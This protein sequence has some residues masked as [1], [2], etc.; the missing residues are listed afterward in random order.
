MPFPPGFLEEL[1]ARNPIEQVISRY[2]D[3]KR[4][5]SNLVGLCPFHSERSPSFTVFKDHFHCF[6]CSAG[7]DVI[8]FVMRMENLE[9]PDAIRFLADRCGM[10]VPENDAGVFRKKSALTRERSFAM[11]KLAARHFYEN[12]NT[13]E[14]AAAREYLMQKR[15]LT[16]ATCIRFGLGYAK[17]SFNDLTDML[18]SQG[19]TPEEIQENFLCGFSKKNGRPFDMFR[20]RVMFPIIDTTGNIIA[21]G[22]R[23]MDDSKPKYLNSSDT[24][25]FKKS[26]NLFALN[27]AKNV[28]LGDKT[29][30]DS[31][32]M[33]EQ[34]SYARPGELII[35]EGYMDVIA[36]HQGG[37]GN[38]V[39]TLGTAI[40]SEHARMIARYAKVVYLAYDSDAAGQNATERAIRL[41]GEA[42]VDAKVIQMTGAKDPDEYIKAYGAPA[43]AKLLG[44][45]E[46]Q[47]DF[48]LNGILKKYN[49]SE[50]DDKLAAV[51]E[52]CKMLAAIRSDVKREVYA[53]RLSN[54]LSLSPESINA[55]IKYAAGAENKR[56]KARRR[57]EN[58][59]SLL[60]YGDTVNLQAAANR[61]ATAAE[62][63]ILGILMLYPELLPTVSVTAEDFVTEF[64]R[65]LFERLAA[66]YQSGET[67]IS[68]LNE[69]YTP[70]QYSYI[71]NMKREREGLSANGKDTVE[72]QLDLL[73][74]AA[75]KSLPKDEESLSD[76]I[77]RIRQEKKKGS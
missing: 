59:K 19:Y 22:G 12:L 68:A 9:Y 71:L 47:I 48:K 35:C 18:I 1:K 4:A 67:D 36:M 54:L 33:T 46:G 41:L 70:E 45:S 60:G 58:Q 66:L 62:Q 24:V 23:V 14:G 2:V 20:N 16:R 76:A 3:L 61:G 42:G 7:G 29:S 13:P 17:N 5:G 32:S 10:T 56:I 73:K 11:N 55:E 57:E 63:R 40:T 8:T 64:N 39:A 31:R 6:G 75:K 37:F 27:F 65:T 25:V 34:T 43:F 77:S 44:N 52:A 50:P 21:F 15:K 72:N 69:F 28:V 53:K 38:A 74:K 26:R 30:D 51:R 49:L